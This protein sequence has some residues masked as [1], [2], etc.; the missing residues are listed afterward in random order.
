MGQH[1]I[2]EY[3]DMKANATHEVKQTISDSMLSNYQGL[4]GGTFEDGKLECNEEYP[5]TGSNI[6]LLSTT[7]DVISIDDLSKRYR[8]TDEYC[9]DDQS[10]MQRQYNFIYNNGLTRFASKTARCVQF[11]LAT[12]RTSF[13]V[14]NLAQI[15]AYLQDNYLSTKAHIKIDLFRD[16]KDNNKLKPSLLSLWK[17]LVDLVRVSLMFGFVDSSV[18]LRSRL[19]SVFCNKAYLMSLVN[20]NFIKQ[21][22]YHLAAFA[23]YAKVQY[24]S[25]RVC[26]T[27]KFNGLQTK[28]FDSG[29]FKYKIDHNLINSTNFQDSGCDY[30]PFLYEAEIFDKYSCSRPWYLFDKKWLKWFDNI[31]HLTMEEK[32]YK[33]SLIDSICRGIKKGADRPSEEMAHQSNLSTF[34]LFT[35]AKTEKPIFQKLREDPIDMEDLEINISVKDMEDQVT[36]T[37]DEIFAGVHEP[38]LTYGRFPSLSACVENKFSNAGSLLVVKQHVPKYPRD[39][40]ANKKYGLFKN[41]VSKPIII[42]KEIDPP[43]RNIEVPLLPVDELDGSYVESKPYIEIE[44]NYENL[45]TDLDIDYLVRLCLENGS[46]MKLVA[47]LEALKIRG[48]ST[49]NALETFL[50]KPIQL[51]LSKLLLKFAC[52]AVTGTPL[53]PEHLEAVIKSLEQGQVFNSGDY[54]NA[55][56][57]MIGSYTE[58]CIRRICYCLNLSEDY[59]ELCVNSLCRNTVIYKYFDE[60]RPKGQRNVELV[61]EQMEAQPMGKVLSF[62]VLCIINLTVCRKSVEID[63]GRKILIKDFPGLI[64]GDDCCFPIRDPQIW[65]KCSA[66]VGLKNSIGKTFFSKDFIEMN[67]R[68]FLVDLDRSLRLPSGDIIFPKFREVPFINFGLVKNMIRSQQ[69]NGDGPVGTRLASLG[70]CH[71]EMVKGLDFCYDSLDYLFRGH[72]IDLLGLEELNGVPYYVPKWLGGLGL[73]PGPRYMEKVS[74]F[75][76]QCASVIFRDFVEK[77]P[78]LINLNKTCLMDDHISIMEKALAKELD[79][80]FIE[81]PYQDLELESGLETV[82]LKEENQEAY[83]ALVEVLWRNLHLIDLKT[84]LEDKHGNPLIV[85]CRPTGYTDKQMRHLANQYD[86]YTSSDFFTMSSHFSD[87]L[88][89][90]RLRRKFNYNGKLWRKACGEVNNRED[91]QPLPWYKLWHQKQ[92]SFLPLV[93]RS[94]VRDQREVAFERMR[95]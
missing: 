89:Q 1:L 71:T 47:L 84:D 60:K 51:F 39:V 33:M 20:F 31:P 92:R 49:A 78:E 10:I 41:P 54:D 61:G 28:K 74:D 76:R 22:K 77:T 17:L 48:I 12:V 24:R 55:T 8:N 9:L 91:I 43:I 46:Q 53:T 65:V 7:T 36:R 16:E 30:P 50:L 72:N 69:G 85:E 45:G 11:E 26:T 29:E 23:T 88:N 64:N 19:L 67:S 62:V 35:T 82:S 4:E 42:N 75:H 3:D 90:K 66:M 27:V 2:K 68:S 38:V 25:E 14:P 15:L 18:N 86:E 40:K 13:D 59:T 95:G 34:K 6:D 87:Y 73:D 93:I 57:E 81:I 70:D 80:P 58:V 79:V 94:A 56:N 37:V 52:F 83:V 5:T 32:L 44:S 21:A 63:Q